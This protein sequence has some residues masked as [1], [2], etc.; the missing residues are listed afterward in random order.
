MIF[1]LMPVCVFMFGK[2]IGK[3]FLDVFK[4][5]KERVGLI[6]QY[7]T[8]CNLPDLSNKQV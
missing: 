5:N 8:Y 3:L 4:E 7:P 1:T 6:L 2:A